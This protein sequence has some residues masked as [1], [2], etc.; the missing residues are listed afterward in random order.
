M[1]LRLVM[2]YEFRKGMSVGTAQKKNISAVYVD[3][4][5][6]LHTVK[7]GLADFEMEI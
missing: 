7:K 4:A 1:H 6:S 3:R 5:L 2:L